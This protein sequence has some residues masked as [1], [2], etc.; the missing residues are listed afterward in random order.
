MLVFVL[1]VKNGAAGTGYPQSRSYASAMEKNRSL[2]S[3]I[4]PTPA[5]FSSVA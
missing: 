4:E 3:V 1:F 5:A 2:S